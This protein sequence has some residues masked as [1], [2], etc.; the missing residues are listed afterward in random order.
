[1]RSDIILP[2]LSRASTGMSP[3]QVALASLPFAALKLSLQAFT[4]IRREQSGVMLPVQP[5]SGCASMNNEVRRTDS[6]F[7]TPPRGDCRDEE[8]PPRSP[9]RARRVLA[10]AP[11][12]PVGTEVTLRYECDRVSGPSCFAESELQRSLE[13]NAQRWHQDMLRR[14][15]EP[16][17]P[18]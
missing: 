9:D 12:R 3:M 17:P 14:G 11:A 15:Y 13:G 10:L 8:I 7:A 5:E 2:A 16:L 1:M 6:A 4:L 18:R